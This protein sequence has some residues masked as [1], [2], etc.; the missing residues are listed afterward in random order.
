MNTKSL[1]QAVIVS[2]QWFTNFLNI[3]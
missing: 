3:S 2:I 1:V